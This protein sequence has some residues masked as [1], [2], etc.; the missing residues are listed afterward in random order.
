MKIQ[1]YCEVLF[2][3]IRQSR[4]VI[5]VPSMRCGTNCV[6]EISTENCGEK[7]KLANPVGDYS[8]HCVDQA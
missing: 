7:S 8:S 1:P 3:I 4:L 5:T 2:E 6:L